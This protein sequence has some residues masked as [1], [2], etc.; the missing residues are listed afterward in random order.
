MYTIKEKYAVRRRDTK[1]VRYLLA[2]QSART[3]ACLAHPLLPFSSRVERRNRL[4]RCIGEILYARR[5][6]LAALITAIPV[7][8][9]PCCPLL[10]TT[11]HADKE[12]AL[13]P[14]SLIA[15]R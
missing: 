7:A 11:Q 6:V 8:L 12:K 13:A 10:V 1:K 2:L 14:C 9:G 3:A 5:A 4:S 15:L